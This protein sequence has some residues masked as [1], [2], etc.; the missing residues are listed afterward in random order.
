MP[1]PNTFAITDARGVR[2]V[3]RI[4][5]IEGL[6]RIAEAWGV[7]S[8]QS[9]QLPL[10]A[11][12]LEQM[13]II[14]RVA[15]PTREEKVRKGEEAP[16][17]EPPAGMGPAGVLLFGLMTG[18]P[19]LGVIGA[20]ATAI[21]GG[22]KGKGEPEGKAYETIWGNFTVKDEAKWKKALEKEGV[23]LTE[24]TP[25]LRKWETILSEPDIVFSLI[26]EGVIEPAADFNL[27]GLGVEY[28]AL[29]YNTDV[30]TEQ[31]MSDMSPEVRAAYENMYPGSTIEEIFAPQIDVPPEA[32]A[33][34][35]AYLA[36]DD[37]GGKNLFPYLDKVGWYGPIGQTLQEQ[38]PIEDVQFNMDVTAWQERTLAPQYVGARLNPYQQKI[39]GM[40][41]GWP[42]DL[43]MAMENAVA[44][45]FERKWFD[46]QGE[47]PEV[48]E[49]DE[50]EFAEEWNKSMEAYQVPS[51]IQQR[52]WFDALQADPNFEAS[53][54]AINTM[55]AMT[56]PSYF[57][58]GEF[59]I[60]RAYRDSLRDL[61]DQ[62][63]DPTMGQIIEE[64]FVEAQREF[65]QYPGDL[66]YLPPQVQQE[67]RTGQI[68]QEPIFPA[69]TPPGVRA[70]IPAEQVGER[71]SQMYPME[72]YPGYGKGQQ[73]VQS[74]AQRVF[75]EYLGREFKE[76][77]EL[78]SLLSW[79][80]EVYT[81]YLAE[82]ERVT[83][84]GAQAAQPFEEFV[85]GLGRGYF[86]KL[87][88][89]TKKAVVPGSRARSRFVK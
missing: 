10:V 67:L 23:D 82:P 69:G 8:I 86:E 89:T 33:L 74:E 20:G 6:N 71:F 48:T 24:P 15:E 68:S 50:E 59:D 80:P 83:M 29:Q 53:S 47:H 81:Q 58:T 12:T 5:D 64:A 46:Y 77:D 14:K 3:Y 65:A 61:A 73:T 16:M 7:E 40:V 88:P 66:S 72:K 31:I 19:W 36:G 42:D 37:P 35:D 28:A 62:G 57:R 45:D 4:A 43:R 39:A 32:Q 25:V 84:G 9:M 30:P 79:F 60:T 55:A 34:V 26:K 63:I 44:R 22:G 13:G 49:L 75:Q 51:G 41:R 17:E 76:P 38:L 11:D 52:V 1:E 27:P 18:H 87:I 70:G 2:V 85:G 78:S 56:N 54:R 21:L